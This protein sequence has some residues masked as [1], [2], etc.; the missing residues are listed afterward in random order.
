MSTSDQSGF[1]LIELLVVIA[2][3][4]ILA[5]LALFF[6]IDFFRTYATTSEET[7]LVSALSKARS[8]SLANI[9]GKPHGVRIEPT[10]YTI[11][12]GSTFVANQSSNQF[13]AVNSSVHPQ[14]TID[15]LFAQ[16]SGNATCTPIIP[17]CIITMIGGNSTKTIT[18]NAQGAILW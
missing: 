14:S 17:N 2:I 4:A 16:V 7:T 9:N 5:S 10:G 13:I 1:S 3:F 11:F 12:E 6:S 15:I 8:Q 18:I